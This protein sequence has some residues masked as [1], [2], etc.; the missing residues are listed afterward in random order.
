EIINNYLV[1][2]DSSARRR[3]RR[4]VGQFLPSLGGGA[5]ITA[6]VVHF[7]PAL[8]P[9][10]PGIWAL[11]F[12][13]GAFASRLYLPR[14]PGWVA[15]YYYAAGAWLMWVARGASPLSAWSVGG[16]FAVGQLLASAVLWWNLERQQ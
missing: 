11:C 12:G 7:D 6:G 4:V 14:A 5:A 10:L 3:T 2:D 8:V 1:H 15:L 9:M 16:T 13:V